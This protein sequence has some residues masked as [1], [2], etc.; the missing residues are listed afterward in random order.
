MPTP[1]F[2]C[3]EYRVVRYGVLDAEW[4]S[5]SLVIGHHSLPMHVECGES[6][7]CLVGSGTQDKR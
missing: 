4:V 2:S 6:F 7:V 3:S 1:S 5:R